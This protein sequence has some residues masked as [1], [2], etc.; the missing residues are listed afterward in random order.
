[1]RRRANAEQI[2]CNSVSLF[3]FFFRQAES[4]R[5]KDASFFSLSHSPRRLRLTDAIVHPALFI[6][7][8]D[9]NVRKSRAKQLIAYY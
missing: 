1:M 7:T 9:E 8:A 5:E 6:R 4:V 2:A 3:F